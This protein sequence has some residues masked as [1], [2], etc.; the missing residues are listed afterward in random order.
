[1]NKPDLSQKSTRTKMILGIALALF[2]AVGG[3]WYTQR[4]FVSTNNAYV[5]AHI[6]QISAQVSGPVTQVFVSDNETVKKDTPLFKIDPTPFHLAVSKTGAQVQQRLAELKHAK[7]NAKRTASLVEQKYLSPQA[8]DD[9]VTAVKTAEAAYNEAKASHEQAKL[10]LEHTMVT[11]PVTGVVA[12][13]SLRPGTVVPASVPQFAVIG[14]DQYW[15][16]ANFKE[17]ELADIRP[18]DHVEIHVDTYPDHVFH[19]RVQSVS[20]GAG[21]AFSL[22]PPQNATGNWVK[23]T[24]RVPVRIMVTDPDPKYPLRVGTSAEVKVRLTKAAS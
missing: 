20:G 5:G 2:V 6:V 19:G 3:Y 14:S 22:L 10:D 23:V 16:D 1:M 21:T 11:A 9:A 8:G 12:N 13:L 18:E 4:N 24:Q 15:V 17:T 7:D